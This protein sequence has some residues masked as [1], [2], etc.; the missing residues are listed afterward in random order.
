MKVRLGQLE[1][2]DLTPEEL[3]DL[4]QRYGVA[5]GS[6]P[7]PDSPR[8][9]KT[10][11][12]GLESGPR[13][14]VVLRAFVDAGLVGVPVKRVGSLL[15]RGGKAMRNAARQWAARIHLAHDQASDPFEDCRVGTGRGIRIKADLQDLA[16]ELL[17]EGG[18]V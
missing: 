6:S 12:K 8:P 9:S 18:G 7:S 13:D 16:Q 1:F 4:V 14:A 5:I 17:K 11:Q 2:I 15:G 10:W 3:E